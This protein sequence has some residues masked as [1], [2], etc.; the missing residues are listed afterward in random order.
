MKRLYALVGAVVAGAF[1]SVS[2]VTTVNVQAESTPV[3]ASSSGGSTSSTT[4]AS[5]AGSS[6]QTANSQS[7]SVPASTNISPQSASTQNSAS[8][9]TSASSQASPA[10]T[11]K[12]TTDATNAD[13]SNVASIN[14]TQVNTKA[15]NADSSSDTS[16]TDA[17]KPADT[18]TENSGTSSGSPNSTADTTNSTKLSITKVDSTGVTVDRSNYYDLTNAKSETKKDVPL[19][20][21]KG[22]YYHGENNSANDP[23]ENTNAINSTNV[24]TNDNA[25]DLGE[26]ILDEQGQNGAQ[27]TNDQKAA[28]LNTAFNLTYTGSDGKQIPAS[29]VTL[30]S[31]INGSM[32]FEI[33]HSIWQY[34]V[35]GD[36]FTYQLPAGYKIT[37]TQTGKIQNGNSNDPNSPYGTYTIGT[38]GKISLTFYNPSVSGSNDA[39]AIQSLQGS[40]T[41]KATFND[42]VITNPGQQGDDLKLPGQTDQDKVIIHPATDQSISKTGQPDE[43]LDPANVIWSVY[44]N[45]NMQTMTNA[46]LTEEFDKNVTYDNV[47]KPVEIYAI[48]VDLKGNVIKN[49]DGSDALGAKLVVGTDYTVDA[50][51]KV[52]FLKQITT[53]Y[54]LIYTTSINNAAKPKDTHGNIKTGNVKLN[55]TV[56]QRDDEQGT[57]VLPA[58]A[59]IIAHYEGLFYKYNPAISTTDKKNDPNY[60][61]LHHIYTW[62]VAYNHGTDALTGNTT[63]YTDV[64]GAPQTFVDGS[65]TMWVMK[66]NPNNANQPFNYTKQQVDPSDYTLTPNADGSGFTVKFKEGFNQAV[67]MVYQTQVKQGTKVI[68]TDVKDNITNTAEVGG[69]DNQ[70]PKTITTNSYNL[71][72]DIENGGP[73]RG[74]KVATW[75]ITI[76]QSNYVMQD[77]ML[78]DTATNDGLSLPFDPNDALPNSTN[79]P[80]VQL[81][82]KTTNTP[83]VEGTDYYMSTVGDQS[84][85]ATFVIVFVGKY[86]KTS[87]TFTLRY[88]TVYDV[89]RVKTPLPNANF[90]FDNYVTDSWTDVTTDKPVTDHAD[91]HFEATHDEAYQ[92]SKNG[93]YDPV[94][95]Q[96][97]WTIIS[98]YNAEDYTSYQ[99][100]DPIYQQQNFV[101]GS[102]KVTQG[103][104][105]AQ[106]FFIPGATDSKYYTVHVYKGSVNKT[107]G[108]FDITGEVKADGSITS[109]T[110]TTSYQ[111]YQNYEGSD[112]YDLRNYSDATTEVI[113]D[114]GTPT[115]L[116]KP[117]DVTGTDSRIKL[118]YQVE[119]DTDVKNLQVANMYNNIALTNYPI[120]NDGKLSVHGQASTWTGQPYISKTGS[121]DQNSGSNRANWTVDINRSQSTVNNAVF[122]DTPTI[123]QRIDPS[124][125]HIYG[126]V[127]KDL[128]T[129]E[130]ITKTVTD[131]NGNEVKK[132]FTQSKM[133]PDLTNELKQ[134]V[135][136]TVELSHD[137]TTGQEKL[138]IKFLKTI[139]TAYVLEYQSK[140]YFTKDDQG[141]A[142]EFSNGATLNG[143]NVTPDKP[144][145]ENTDHFFVTESSAKAIGYFYNLSFT[146]QTT[147]GKKLS[148]ITFNLYEENADQTTGALLR[149]GQTDANGV[150]TF[151]NIPG[152][153]VD[154][155]TPIE[156]H[157]QEVNPDPNYI[158]PD[159]LRD[160]T[161][162]VSVEMLKKDGKNTDTFDGTIWNQLGQITLTKYGKNSLTDNSSKILPGAQFKLQQSADG[163]TNWTDYSAKTN[164]LL[165]DKN[166]QII[167]KYLLPGYY[168]FV[169]T[170]APAG[171]ILPTQTDANV[172]KVVHITV[173]ATAGD[174]A[175]SDEEPSLAELVKATTSVNY[176]GTLSFTK[177][178]NQK[179]LPGVKF[180][181]FLGQNP[182]TN[183]ISYSDKT[184]KVI[185][186]GL[187]A[188]ETYT[189]REM[190]TLDGYYPLDA[191]GTKLF[192]VTVVSQSTDGTDNISHDD[193]YNYND[194]ITLTKRGNDGSKVV[195][196]TFVLMSNGQVIKTLTTD[197]NG[198]L[199]LSGQLA[200]GDYTLQET[201]APAGYILNNTPINFTIHDG[202]PATLDQKHV[203]NIFDFNLI[204]YR[205]QI[206]VVKVDAETKKPLKGVTYSLTSKK[207]NYSETQITGDDGVATFINL[208][209]SDDYTLQEISAPDGYIVSPVKTPV[210]IVGNVTSAKDTGYQVSNKFTN[211]LNHITFTKYLSLEDNKKS[212]GANAIYKIS[213]D[214]Q[215]V[216]EQRTAND[217][218]FTL[219]GLKAGHYV[220]TEKTAPAGYAVNG[221]PIEFDVRQ[222]GTIS[223][224]SLVQTDYQGYA[225]LAKTDATSGSAMPG[226]KFE[227]LDK[228]QKLIANGLLNDGLTNDQGIVTTHHLSAGT[229]YFREVSTLPGYV[230]DVTLQ[231]FT[232]D[233][234]KHDATW[235]VEKTM[236]NQRNQITF[237]KFNKAGQ[238][239]SGAGYTLTNTSTG[240]KTIYD[241][242]DA[243]SFTK[244]LLTAGV[245]ALAETTAPTGYL[246]N[247][248]KITFTVNAD[249][250]I[251]TTDAQSQAAVSLSQKDYQGRATWSKTDDKGTP[252]DGATFN[253]YDSNDKLVQANVKSTDNVFTTDALPTGQ[254]YF[255]EVVAP[256]GYIINKRKVLFSIYANDNDLLIHLGNFVNSK[257]SLSFYK[258]DAKNG[259]L[260]GVKFGIFLGDAKEPAATAT[261]DENGKVT[262]SDLTAGTTYTVRELASTL[263]EHYP[264]DAN[265]T[266]LFDVTVASQSADGTD[267]ISHAD[268][269]NYN[270]H[271]TL[272]KRG[273]DG[274]KVVGA[275]FVLMS[276]GKVVKT[277]TT[278]TDGQLVLSG[279]LTKGDYTLQEIAAP[280]GY[281]L[282]STPMT[283]TVKDA[284]NTNVDLHMVDY[285]GQ[286][287]VTKTD[288]NKQALAGVT[289]RL[290]DND[291]A[292]RDATT[293]ANGIALFDRLNS[294]NYK[295]QEIAAPAGYI[296]NH[297]V[298]PLF[299][300]YD[301]NDSTDTTKYQ[302]TQTF[303]N[304]QNKI[305]FTKYLNT[306]NPANKGINATYELYYAANATDKKA[307]ISSH[308]T[309]QNGQITFTGL[310]AGYYELIETNAPT[311]YAINPDSL[312]FDVANDG[313]VS[314]DTLSQVD[315]QG[316]AQLKKTDAKGQALQGVAFEL[317]DADKHVLTDAL[318]NGGLTDVNGLITT[319]GLKPGT[320]YFKEVKTLSGY[321]LN[322]ELKSVTISNT[323]SHNAAWLAAS[324][325]M[326]NS[327]NE[328]TFTKF[329]KNS[330]Q[331]LSGATYRLTNVATK[332][333]SDYTTVNGIFT[334]T[335]LAQGVYTLTEI[336]AP[337]N[338]LLNPDVLTF[339]VDQ[340]GWINGQAILSLN[341]RD[342]QGYAKWFKV[343][344]DENG[345]LHALNGA[346][347]NVYREDGTLVQ[348][349][350]QA[351]D[352]AMFTT[353]AL[354]AG[355]YYAQEVSAPFNYILNSTKIQFEIT[356]SD[357]DILINNGDFINYTGQIRVAKTDKNTQKPLANVVYRLTSADGAIRDITTNVGGIAVFSQLATGNYRLTEVRAAD[358]YL[359]DR[360]VYNFTIANDVRDAT[361][362]FYNYSV[363][364]TNVQN[365]ITFT[366]LLNTY[367]PA[368]KGVGANY[369]LRLN[370]ELVKNAASTDGKWATDKNGQIIFTGLKTGEYVMNEVAAPAGY[371]I[372]PDVIKFSVASDGTISAKA[373]SQID[374]QGYAQLKKT[375][376]MG[377]ALKGVAF[378]LLDADKH[379]LADALLNGGLTDANGL[380][381]TV[382]LKPGTYY[383]KEV[384]TLSGYALN[385][386]LKAVT[387]SNTDSHDAAWL[388]A[389]TTM[390]NSQNEI[391]FT[392]F[393]KNSDMTLS[394]AIYRLTNVDAKQTSD[395]TTANGIF[396]VTGL[397]QGHYTLNEITAPMGYLVNPDVL[398]FNV[399]QN[400]WINGQ[401]ILML[402][403]RDYQGYAKWHKVSVDE[404][405]THHSL[406]GATFDVYR[407]DGTLVQANVQADENDVFKTD[408]LLVG[409]YYAKEMTTPAGYILNPNAITF[410]ITG[411]DHDVVVDNGDFANYTDHVT[412]TKVGNDGS[413]VIGATFVLMN[414]GHTVKTLTTD[415]N[416]QFDLVG[417]AAGNYTLQETAA[418]AGYIV[419]NTPV[420]F[421]I[422]TDHNNTLALSLVD[423][424]GQIQITKT[425]ATT[426][427]PLAGV[428]YR[429]TAADGAIMDA[430]TDANGI[431]LFK[432]LSSGTY[433]IVEIKTLA[434]YVLDNAAKLV[435][436]AAT[437]QNAD[438]DEYDVRENY[439]NIK[440]QLT[441]VKQ[442]SNGIAKLAGATYKLTDATNNTSTQYLTDSNGRFT[443]AGLTAGDY[444]LNEVTAPNGYLINPD[445]L[446][447]TVSANGLINGQQVLVLSQTDYQG[448]ASLRKVD[449]VDG[450]TLANA[451]F[452]VYDAHNN[453]IQTVASGVDGMVTTRALNAGH[454]YFKELK[455]P[456]GY[457]LNTNLVAFDIQNGNHNELVQTGDFVNW[458]GAVKMTKYGQT[459]VNNIA[460]RHML[461]GTTFELYYV[462]D[463][464]VSE[465][466][467]IDGQS[468]F[469]TDANGQIKLYGLKPGNYYFKEV[470]HAK[471]YILR[472][473]TPDLQPVLTKGLGAADLTK[474]RALEFSRVDAAQAVIAKDGRIVTD[475]STKSLSNRL[476]FM[477]LP[478]GLGARVAFAGDQ[479]N[480]QGSVTF[481]K[482]NS[483]GAALAGAVYQLLDGDK[484]VKSVMVDG[485]AQT[486]WTTG[487]NGQFE[488]TG[489]APGT[490]Y[491]KEIVA[492]DGYLINDD[493]DATKFEIAEV[494]RGGQ[495]NV[496]AG[497]IDYL[498]RV[499]LTKIDAKTG[500][501]LANAHFNL[502]DANGNVVKANLVTDAAGELVVTDLEPGQYSFQ[503]TVA[504]AGYQLNTALLTVI[505]AAHSADEPAF[506][507]AQFK[508]VQV[509]PVTPPTTP[510]VPNIPSKPNTPITPNVPNIPSKPNTPITPNVPNIP[511]KPNTPTTPN[512]PNVPSKPN[513]PTKPETPVQPSTPKVV[514]PA[515]HA[516]G[517]PAKAEGHGVG[518]L[519]HTGQSATHLLALLGLVL[520]SIVFGFAVYV[521][522]HEA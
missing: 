85:N 213:R 321:V 232:I 276:N 325:T 484:A 439:T 79:Q 53:P 352:Q 141:K 235:F 147:D 421:T 340:N 390:Q 461:A 204:D 206:S 172:S 99:L 356:N 478:A 380:V 498:G 296:V 477:I 248:D 136:Y 414:N 96:I 92:G 109:M 145:D 34:V 402:N 434:G 196:A 275:T 433:R 287:T 259:A 22:Q 358:G 452:G 319:V 160:G 417:L 509:P 70:T 469:V 179:V 377:Q 208:S 209:S 83:L 385:E 359:L 490:Y 326:Q 80:K 487:Q 500:H 285:R 354:L 181:L 518:E 369:E 362:R 360:T 234:N 2:S 274:S 435:T 311:G 497:Q 382:S 167:V 370:G 152:Y 519:P 157:I 368:N 39:N 264:L 479:T 273:N 416:G 224:A 148:G 301:V 324:T 46:T 101:P 363:A 18:T 407:E 81:I 169:E 437:V 183:Q 308:K 468:R 162:T 344:V 459:D 455:A 451:L 88:K 462:H 443:I 14:Q 227:L 173:P 297:N 16:A 261:S 392:K 131:A 146:K 440:N 128:N 310:K 436:I 367:S 117:A 149:T 104:I 252:L 401:K 450:H 114:F 425:D 75:K 126:V 243:T 475:V 343:S 184:G 503:E 268:V 217:G 316:Y 286:L 514:V 430:T 125:I 494:T 65:F 334:V 277:L 216:G 304:V 309:D 57:T 28:T 485:Q 429:L 91:N 192:D 82:D 163:V 84:S 219:T 486:Q 210:T 330:D 393:A 254:Y 247:P 438:A 517:K 357:H 236:Q 38:D 383:F 45:K 102:V 447:F 389:S 499:A 202:S 111:G 138:T 269:Y 491:F 510:N 93:V 251:T 332:Q 52:T 333:T 214:G 237:T 127:A 129:L 279:E 372:N 394:G 391:T 197:T 21:D 476:Y 218:T 158:T 265:G 161:R 94:T 346:A 456:A 424:R 398:T 511:S 165:T 292:I 5:N 397:A 378:E 496:M 156:Y 215:N 205:G 154:G 35:T 501:V 376:A 177:R 187:D 314:T 107:T 108:D 339:N 445:V 51:G 249:G 502:L 49:A 399:D 432:N 453:L 506:V 408:A 211:Q 507:M 300:T 68:S 137:N 43:N 185:F 365:T 405:G 404:K 56:D 522:K 123:N 409:K 245:Y 465:Q 110:G 289:Y 150:V 442:G 464:G 489:L 327:Q 201:V 9:T 190:Q 258:K 226:V 428:V 423:Y 293:D 72:K 253:V 97:H 250:T 493:V 222:D 328:I 312:S 353:N 233:G 40:L 305:T 89:A 239:L 37:S 412:F 349:N 54:K 120:T 121:Y 225:Q 480:Y 194:H 61:K 413:K 171:Y 26:Y 331:M 315:F 87:D 403:Q 17:N 174:S 25:H 41:F 345:G 336:T 42:K 182:V 294:G 470:A 164:D 212:L 4:D 176:K 278:D 387:I 299:I 351:N 13:S 364:Y 58:S 347:F 504:P 203:D 415:A 313:N 449:M 458:Q 29:Q 406:V 426:N 62:T 302:L 473:D 320:Y 71:I 505:V 98:N 323:D 195:G 55:N 471:G 144:G 122:T 366:K 516:T 492:P 255:T 33:P 466:V 257:G 520:L 178:D 238:P 8:Q 444:V 396:T 446:T 337:K 350:V 170:K 69:Y 242:K 44:M 36:T 24:N 263:K 467:T 140:L 373:L 66:Y 295:L 67:N 240:E 381:K 342:Y 388:A 335:G 431:A 86:K 229:Y 199:Q 105:A 159:D 338:Y 73:D 11:N 355:K 472:K 143:D 422:S 457:I 228:N 441:F 116:P 7:S 244:D 186:I 288:A 495:S 180:E 307:A 59:S 418:P 329:A 142:V 200:K 12:Q 189:V 95:K 231:E 188:G 427:S 78:R 20:V 3:V 124:T 133:T 291:G 19:V 60:D 106:G 230:K 63:T 474:S 77:Y 48:Q 32:S 118:A 460:S 411:M 113:V 322:Q 374:F 139:T 175:F 317:L 23:S 512:V 15:T 419:N 103:S 27:A 112:F 153:H 223:V 298:T 410:E 31:G 241:M 198:Q 270:E 260:A 482:T 134:G 508:D 30:A 513:T 74:L 395:Y 155:K 47:N 280:A 488:I 481:S 282:N 283:F 64:I 266:K 166:G 10:D 119:Y 420:A 361:N 483:K 220:L 262:F 379:V 168:R 132:S 281:I 371:A 6:D 221:T 151:I 256:A 130:T 1:F 306:Y 454:Y 272:T 267:K 318:Q 515:G 135:D 50:N 386:E 375:D 448:F 400:G 341:Q 246:L 303:I 193:I 521:E 191:N 207:L 90:T 100:L 463:N 348:A 290:T 115:A 384:K 271:I 76:N 284:A